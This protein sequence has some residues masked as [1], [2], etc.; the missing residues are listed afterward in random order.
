MWLWLSTGCTYRNHSLVLALAGPGLLYGSVTC[1]WAPIH[2][3][4]CFRSRLNRYLN[5]FETPRLNNLMLCKYYA[6]I[7]GAG[8]DAFR[9]PNTLSRGG[10]RG[11]G[12]GLLG[13][14]GGAGTGGRPL[15]REWRPG[16]GN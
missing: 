7:S 5:L 11:G 6:Q 14:A 1:E 16:G 4:G 13:S 3:V 10:A 15:S 12:G 2:T 9:R 8:A